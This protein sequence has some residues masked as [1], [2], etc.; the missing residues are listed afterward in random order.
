VQ[1][2]AG[3]LVLLQAMGTC[4]MRQA[5]HLVLQSHCLFMPATLAACRRVVPRE[6][7]LV[8]LVA[9]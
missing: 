6:A 8:H 9:T 1:P 4:C 2:R 5:L 7:P 3:L